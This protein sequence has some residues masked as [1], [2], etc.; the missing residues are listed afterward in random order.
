MPNKTHTEF[1]NLSPRLRR[2]L[3]KISRINDPVEI[4]FIH[5]DYEI[6]PFILGVA[7]NEQDH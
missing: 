5:D 3:D 1:E 4:L 7:E 6:R 2:I